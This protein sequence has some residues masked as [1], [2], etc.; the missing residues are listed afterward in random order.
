MKDN[1]SKQSNQYAQFR[2]GYPQQ[3]YDF[4]L[5][6][7]PEKKAAWDCGTG[8]GQ[9][10]LKLSRYFDKVYATDLS[11]VQISNAIKRKNIFY[12]VEMAE[13]T[14]FDQNTFDLITVA[15]A[16]HWFNFEKFYAEANRTLKPG[17]IIAII[18]Y[19]I[20]RINEEINSMID[21]FYVE[22][23]GPYWDAERKY[24]DGNYKTIP[25]PFKEIETPGFEMS[26]NWQFGQVI[27][28]LNTWSAVQHYIRKNNENPVDKFSVD[29]RKA[30]GKVL[31]R[32]VTFPIF[33]RISRH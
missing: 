21:K 23:T 19:G 16:I 17:G 4:V 33:S 32:K 10:A 31:K 27:G 15:Q 9:V 30:W 2:P 14:L 28:F 5:P 22:T 25:F 13:K 29:L 20:F 11:A 8:N 6:L 3:L 18:G 7:V 1:F 12:A 24:V 26:Y